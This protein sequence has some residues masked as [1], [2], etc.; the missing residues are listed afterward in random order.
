MLAR[1]SFSGAPPTL[2]PVDFVGL[3]AGVKSNEVWHRIDER[4]A[5]FCC[6]RVPRAQ[7]LVR[8]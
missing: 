2:A 8:H 1:I 6:N 5:S 3:T 4:T 7:A